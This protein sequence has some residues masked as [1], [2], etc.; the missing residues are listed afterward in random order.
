MCCA[1]HDARMHLLY[2]H[3]LG[4]SL[5][6]QPEID[7]VFAA[8]PLRYTITRIAVPYHS[9]PLELVTRLA[10]STFGDLCM[11]V[12]EG[13]NK[14]VETARQFPSDDY[15]AVGDSLGGFISLV[16]AERDQRISHCIL[17]ACSG[18]FCNAMMRLDKLNPVFGAMAGNFTGAGKGGIKEQAH[19]AIAGQSDFQREFELINT[20]EPQRLA[21]LRR[22]LILGDRGDPVAPE[23]A[24]LHF[25][26]GVADATVRMVY[27]EGQHHPI[28]KEA[29]KRY[30][31]PFLL[32]K[33]V[34]DEPPFSMKRPALSL[35]SPMRVRILR[36]LRRLLSSPYG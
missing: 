33:P 2:T 28:G 13:A 29:L 19:R 30:A 3:G 1:R 15:V 5:Q 14:L 23:S 27:D 6:A 17:L 25:A 7:E 11:W 8:S 24:C 22:L 36:I 21:R 35:A 31:V 32:N 16:A 34:P 18:D 10:T 4:G 26:R 12:H 20:F 9:N